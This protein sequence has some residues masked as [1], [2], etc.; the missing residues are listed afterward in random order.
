MQD[1]F[2]IAR[3]QIKR[4]GEDKEGEF[5]NKA[6]QVIRIESQSR[7]KSGKKKGEI[8][9]LEEVFSTYANQ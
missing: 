7:Q 8:T 5:V 9:E 6:S 4:V 3:V 1:T 2:F